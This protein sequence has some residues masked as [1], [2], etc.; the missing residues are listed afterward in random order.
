MSVLRA[1]SKEFGEKRPLEGLKI[2]IAL[3]TEA[4][5]LG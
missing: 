3:H 2:G 4:I 5:R 1:L